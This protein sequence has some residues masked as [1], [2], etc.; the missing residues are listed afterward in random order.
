MKLKVFAIYDKAAEAYMT[1]F[2]MQT[3]GQALRAWEDSCRDE[4]TQ[5][6]KH[7]SDFQL[8][9]IG[10]YDDATGTYENLESRLSFGTALQFKLGKIIEAVENRKEA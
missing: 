4:N 9:E 5:F 7:P 3:A 2:H 8:F 6:A 10:T 1:P